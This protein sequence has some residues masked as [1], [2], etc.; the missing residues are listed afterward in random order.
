VALALG[1]AHLG[2]NRTRPASWYSGRWIPSPA[3][4]S[5]SLAGN[6]SRFGAP[7]QRLLEWTGHPRIRKLAARTGC[8]DFDL[9]PHAMLSRRWNELMGCGVGAVMATVASKVKSLKVA[10]P[11]VIV[12][13]LVLVSC[14]RLPLSQATT[15]ADF[16][17]GASSLWTAIPNSGTWPGLPYESGS[18]VQK[19]F[20]WRD[21]YDWRSETSPKLSVKGLRIDGPAKPLA[22]SAATNAFA[23]DIGSSMIVL[24]QIPAPGC[25]KITGQYKEASLSFVVWVPA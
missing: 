15:S 11:I 1:R 2:N 17:Y 7:N 3:S 24:V 6:V 9:Q 25:W 19:V 8:T 4:F 12:A 5:I 23:A 21:G 18:Y 16:W 10:T 20:W 14:G 13:A 22:S